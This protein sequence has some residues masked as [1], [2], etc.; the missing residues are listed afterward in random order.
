MK[1]VIYFVAIA[2]C[3]GLGYNANAQ[4]LKDLRA[5]PDT[6]IV[7]SRT[8]K[9][10]SI[11]NVKVPIPEL[12]LSVDY[13]KHWTKIGF[14]LN[15]ASFSDNWRDGGINSM[16]W[17][18]TAWHKSEYNRNDFNF[19]TEM[20]LRYGV[21]STKDQ[22]ARK[23]VDRI[24]WDNKLAYKFSSN[25]S[26]FTSVAFESIFAPGYQNP[27]EDVRGPIITRFM[28]PGYLTET[29]G[30]EYK[31]DN[32]FSLRFGTG[33]ARQTFVLDSDIPTN[34]QVNGVDTRFG[35]LPGRTVRNELGV[36][37]LAN[38]DR[39]LSKNLHIKSRYQLLADYRELTN[40]D[41][42]LDV[43]LTAKVTRFI[44]VTANGTLLYD[45]TWRFED[46]TSPRVQYSQ[47]LAM[48]VLFNFPRQ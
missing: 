28:S 5:R 9:P 34:G 22:R 3:V 14:N 16:A 23:N 35:V 19:T 41:H 29:L 4:D 47:A 10:L 24:F 27:S 30:L 18:T 17:A 1:Q 39:D 33:A 45:R 13:W 36:Q 31:P 2:T 46:E 43:T 15:Q 42:R 38:L 44:S 21:L 7:D 6:S 11:R 8:T 48:G 37:I 26:V 25:W 32:T 20:D 40:P 12:G